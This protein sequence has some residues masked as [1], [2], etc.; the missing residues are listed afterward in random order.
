[1]LKPKPEKFMLD[2]F[3]LA[4]VYV[5]FFKERQKSK[6]VFKTWSLITAVQ[7]HEKHENRLQKF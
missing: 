6:A 3:L 2:P 1:M 7:K 4:R 5:D